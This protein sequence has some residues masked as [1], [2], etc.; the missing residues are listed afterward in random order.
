MVVMLTQEQRKIISEG[1]K[2]GIPDIQ[3]AERLSLKYN[4]IYKFRKKQ[5]IS[6]KDML[7]NR[8]DTWEKMIR[9][10]ESLDFIAKIYGFKP[11]SIRQMLWR[12]RQFSFK[13]VKED[14]KMSSRAKQTKKFSKDIVKLFGF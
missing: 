9:D 14:I 10:G 8:L 3:I 13:Q 4:Q 12:E 5:E 1:F 7:K 6:A 11:S 2:L